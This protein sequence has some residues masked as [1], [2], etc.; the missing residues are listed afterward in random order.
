VDVLNECYNPKTVVLKGGQCNA[1][2][3]DLTF[4]ASRE[5]MDLMIEELP[6]Q[7]IWGRGENERSRI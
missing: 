1:F 5:S 4:Q 3:K 6:L 2:R 7:K